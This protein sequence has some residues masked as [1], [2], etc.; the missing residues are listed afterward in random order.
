MV[1][2]IKCTYNYGKEKEKCLVIAYVCTVMAMIS[3]GFLPD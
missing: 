1:A 2:D 3:S